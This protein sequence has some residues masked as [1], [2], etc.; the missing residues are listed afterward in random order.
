MTEHRDLAPTELAKI[1]ARLRE[2]NITDAE[3]LAT[4]AQR[5]WRLQATR[6]APSTIA[7]GQS[8]FGGTPDLPHDVEWPTREGRPLTFLA[9]IDLT[10]VRAS[11]LP[12]AGWLLFFYDAE[13]QL[14]ARAFDKIWLVLQC[15]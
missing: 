11:D 5:S 10:Q 9:Q 13:E 6:A 8:R 3:R 12:A 14:A 15:T 2:A 1:T 7:L 4:F